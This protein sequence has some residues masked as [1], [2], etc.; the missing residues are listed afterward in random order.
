VSAENAAALLL[1]GL[2]AIAACLWAL[3]HGLEWV[4]ERDRGRR[5]TPDAG[6]HVRRLP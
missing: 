3:E 2:A 4:L 6:G 1:L 5:E